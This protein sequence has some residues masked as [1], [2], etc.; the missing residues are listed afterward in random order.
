MTTSEGLIIHKFI[1]NKDINN[2]IINNNDI[3]HSSIIRTK[4]GLW[5]RR[6]SATPT[7]ALKNRL[8]LRLRFQLQ[9]WLRTLIL[10]FKARVTLK[11]SHGCDGFLPVCYFAQS[12]LTSTLHALE[13]SAPKAGSGA[14]PVFCLLSLP[15]YSNTRPRKKEH[16]KT[17]WRKKN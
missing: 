12:R 10:T 13:L 11:L 8:R 2:L 14:A 6:F 17:S 7:P 9:F 5:S 1:D 3:I 15:V 4:P 16:N